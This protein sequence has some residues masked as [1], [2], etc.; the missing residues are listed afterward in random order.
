MSENRT[1]TQAQ[2]HVIALL[3]TGLAVAAVARAA[4]VNRNTV[5]NW[6]RLPIFREALD[7]AR[8]EQTQIWRAQASA[9]ASQALDALMPGPAAA[10]S[11]LAR[12]P[13][14]SPPKHRP[15]RNDP[16]PCGSGRKYKRC[17]QSNH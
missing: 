5:W 16:C 15:G 6:L 17:C 10:R 2:H 12:L 14:P 7:Q 4:G 13:Q 11:I 8:A 9:R 3:S 1:L